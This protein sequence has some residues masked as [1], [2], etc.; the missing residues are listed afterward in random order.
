VLAEEKKCDDAIGSGFAWLKSLPMVNAIAIVS[1][2]LVLYNTSVLHTQG[3]VEFEEKMLKNEFAPN[4]EVRNPNFSITKPLLLPMTP[5]PSTSSCLSAC[6]KPLL[7]PMMLSA[8][9]S[10]Y[11]SAC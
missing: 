9:T 2:A 1:L 8:S 3:V 10:S 4:F 5:S 6:C 11:L 7:L